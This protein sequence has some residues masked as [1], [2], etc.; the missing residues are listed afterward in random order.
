MLIGEGEL[1]ERL[2]LATRVPTSKLMD[3]GAHKAVLLATLSELTL[4][5]LSVLLQIQTQWLMATLVNAI[6]CASLPQV[7]VG[8]VSHQ[9]APLLL[10]K[11]PKPVM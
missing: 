5:H 1:M 2:E 8:Q 3:Q 4:G 11:T 10:L 9:A 6:R 7:E